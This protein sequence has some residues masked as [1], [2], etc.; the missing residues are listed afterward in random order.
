MKGIVLISHGLLAQG[1]AHAAT[2]FMGDPVEQLAF[3]SLRQD[4]AP[5]EFARELK[6]AVETVDT[7]DGVVILADLFGGT[8]CNQAAQLLN[9][10]VDLISGINFP[11]LLELLTAR[12]AGEIDL[13][14]LIERGRSGVSD[15]KALLSRSAYDEEEE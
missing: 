7:G 3:C 2:F 15:V 1:L 11:I 14:A 10:R 13:A 4:S 6:E 8:P 5:E 9:D 12:M